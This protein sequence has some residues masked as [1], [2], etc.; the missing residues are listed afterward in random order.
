MPIAARRMTMCSRAGNEHFE[1][2]TATRSGMAV[3]QLGAMYDAF[4]TAVAL[5]A[6]PPTFGF[7]MTSIESGQSTK[8]L[9][10]DICV[11]GHRA[12]STARGSSDGLEREAPTRCAS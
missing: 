9:T 2:Q 11:A 12:A 3:P 7:T 4:F 1:R 10:G 8:A 5:A 6:P